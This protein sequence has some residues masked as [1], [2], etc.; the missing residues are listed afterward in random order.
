[1]PTNGQMEGLWCRVD[2]SLDDRSQDWLDG[3]G[4]WVVNQL[5]QPS[6][7]VVYDDAADLLPLGRWKFFVDQL[8]KLQQQILHIF[9]V[10]DFLDLFIFLV[11]DVTSS[12]LSLWSVFGRVPAG[13]P[14]NDEIVAVEG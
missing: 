11:V 6:S 14:E 5:K 4:E 8:N 7:E 13:F 1:M 12:R 2:R 10:D 3:F 9:R